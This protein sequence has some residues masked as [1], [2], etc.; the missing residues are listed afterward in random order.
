METLSKV[1]EEAAKQVPSLVVLVIVV[2][3][4]LKFMHQI[5]NQFTGAM[6]E[7]HKDHLAAREQSR[8]AITDNT[9][10]LR[11]LTSVVNVV[12]ENGVRHK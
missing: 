5:S 3:L 8:T 9:I 12:R 10:A 7:L 2:W 4:F 11:E 1:L 6:T